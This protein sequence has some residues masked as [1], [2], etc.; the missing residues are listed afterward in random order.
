MKSK[1]INNSYNTNIN[2]FEKNRLYWNSWRGTILRTV[3]DV[4]PPTKST[5]LLLCVWRTTRSKVLKICGSNSV[6]NAHSSLKMQS[7]GPV[8]TSLGYCM[9]QCVELCIQQVP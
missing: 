8:G 3:I 5:Q 6:I 1:V 7:F 2:S 9:T 4:L